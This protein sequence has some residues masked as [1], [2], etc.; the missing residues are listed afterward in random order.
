MITDPPA[1]DNIDSPDGNLLK[2]LTSEI[3][4]WFDVLN[5]GQASEYSREL[6]CSALLPIALRAGARAA[7]SGGSLPPLADLFRATQGAPLGRDSVPLMGITNPDD[8]AKLRDQQL[9]RYECKGRNPERR[10]DC[11][12]CDPAGTLV[13]C[14]ADKPSH[15]IN[16]VLLSE[17]EREEYRSRGRSSICAACGT[18]L[19][20]GEVYF[21]CAQCQVTKY[22]VKTA[23]GIEPKGTFG[24]DLTDNPDKTAFATF[25]DSG[26]L[27]QLLT[28]ESP[29]TSP[30][31]E[32]F[33]ENM[34]RAREMENR[35]SKVGKVGRIGRDVEDLFFGSIEKRFGRRAFRIEEV[36]SD[37][38]KGRRL[39][40]QL[41]RN[42]RAEMLEDSSVVER[43][44]W[45]LV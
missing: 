36:T 25:D 32:Q 43:S 35:L 34:E 17:A 42:G 29:I 5:K 30:D 24:M 7:A 4:T 26:K 27:E 19:S 38:I 9:R 31:V 22:P 8:I 10:C 16:G 44:V 39:L 33:R 41:Q 14:I 13:T 6:V 12:W 40:N 3:L 23:S 37:A 20:E 1:L 21:Y 45:R 15:D 11:T 18:Q 28:V 2:A